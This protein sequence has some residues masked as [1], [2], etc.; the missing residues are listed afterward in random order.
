MAKQF[1]ILTAQVGGKGRIVDPPE[2]FD[3][4]DYILFTDKKVESKI[5]QIKDYL[6]FSTID[7]AWKHRRN[8]KVFK[9]L[10]TL[11]FPQYEY[12]IWHDSVNKLIV[13]PKDIIKNRE[14]L[15]LFLFIHPWRSCIYK[16]IQACTELGYDKKEILVEQEK[17]YLDNNFPSDQGLIHADV[18]IKKNTPKTNILELMWWEQICKFSSR[19]QCSLSFCLHQ[20]KKTNFQYEVLSFEQKSSWFE[21][22]W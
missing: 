8:A 22:S 10:S 2:A 6:N 1:L 5:W 18:F 9:V 4:A 14:H 17:F 15:D 19:D 16:E 7:P 21:L 11:M 3:N 12:I 20:M 13:D